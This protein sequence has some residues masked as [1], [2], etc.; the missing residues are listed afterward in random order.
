MSYG[1]I[2]DGESLNYQGH[3]TGGTHVSSGADSDTL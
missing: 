3:T 1:H 2:I